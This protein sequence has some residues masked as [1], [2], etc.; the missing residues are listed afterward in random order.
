VLPYSATNRITVFRTAYGR[1]APVG[2]GR[3]G[4]EQPTSQLHTWL[5]GKMIMEIRDFL[6]WGSGSWVDT[7][8]LGDVGLGAAVLTFAVVIFLGFPIA[9]RSCCRLGL[10]LLRSGRL[11]GGGHFRLLA[12]LCDRLRRGIWIWGLPRNAHYMRIYESFTILYG[13][14]QFSFLYG[15]PINLTLIRNYIAE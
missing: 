15:H 4:R 8:R 14:L 9:G 10:R 11:P 13:S 1:A 6:E 12:H 5:E 7:T 3:D 2:R